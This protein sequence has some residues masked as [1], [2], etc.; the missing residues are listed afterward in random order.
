MSVIFPFR[1]GRKFR[2][3]HKKKTYSAKSLTLSIP[4]DLVTVTVP[5]PPPGCDSDD[6][7]VSLPISF[8]IAL[9]YAGNVESLSSLHHQTEEAGVLPTGT[10]SLLSYASNH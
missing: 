7:T 10:V 2:L 3:H 6:K 9:Y 1:M 8:P 4:L 5:L